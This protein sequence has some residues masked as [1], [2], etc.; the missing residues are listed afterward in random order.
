MKRWNTKEVVD[1]LQDDKYEMYTEAPGGD[2]DTSVVIV[3]P[4]DCNEFENLFIRGFI[5][6]DDA[7]E[8][9]DDVDVEMVELSDGQDSIGGLNSR[10]PLLIQAY[11]D[12]R[13]KLSGVGFTIVDNM[14]EYF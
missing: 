7:I 11:A 13:I 5:T 3:H 8:D 14:D 6:G 2:V 4:K 10:D 12:V 1:L 9:W